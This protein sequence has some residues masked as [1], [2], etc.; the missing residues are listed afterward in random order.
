MRRSDDCVQ[1]WT[2]IGTVSII[3]IASGRMTD[4]ESKSSVLMVPSTSSS[5]PHALAPK[6]RDRSSIASAP[7]SLTL[8]KGL[9]AAVGSGVL[10]GITVHPEPPNL[11]HLNKTELVDKGIMGSWK[12]RLHSWG[13]S[14]IFCSVESGHGLDLL[15][16]KLRDQTTVIVGPSGVRKSSLINALRNNPHAFE[17]E[18]ENWFKPTLGSKW[19]VDQRVRKV[20]TRSGR[21]K[22]A[23]RHGGVPVKDIRNQKRRKKMGD[24]GV[25]QA[26]PQ[27]SVQDLFESVTWHPH[28]SPRI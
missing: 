7:T 3:D 2:Y 14:Q 13:M 25:Q 22:H 23:T 20:S 28:A 19:L 1:F 4:Q 10:L 24:M 26:K 18:R 27:N 17:A 6:I 11:L 8:T 12:A 16:F 21:G 9:H 15:A 5:I